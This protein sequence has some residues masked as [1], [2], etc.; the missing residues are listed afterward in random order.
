[1]D[2]DWYSEVGTFMIRLHLRSVLGVWLASWALGSLGLETLARGDEAVLPLHQRIDQLID[3]RRVGPPAPLANDAEFLRRIAIDLTGFPPSPEE[4]TAFLADQGADKRARAIDRLLA[5]PLHG[6]YLANA[7]DLWLMERRA[8][9]HVAAEEWQQYLLAAARENRPLNQVFKEILGADGTNPAVRP[10]ARFYLDREAEP[11]LITRDV[12]RIFLGRDMQCAQC[13]N[14][15]VIADYQ[16]SDYHGLLAFFSPAALQTRK[17][18]GKDQAVYAEKVGGTLAFDSVFV[19]DDHH[20]TG[21]R[22]L[23]E[24]ELVE[25]DFPPGT[26]Y[27]VK[28]AD[29]VVPVPKFSRRTQLASHLTAGSNQAFNANLANRLWALLMGRGLVH[30]L[31]LHHPSNPPSHPELLAL[32]ANELVA[33]NFDARSFLRE[34]A[35]TQT[36]QRA[37]DLPGEAETKAPSA[38]EIASM[39]AV[40]GGRTESLKAEAKAAHDAY[41]AAINA[42]HA[43]ESKLVP[44]MGELTQAE[45]KHAGADKTQADAQKALEAAKAQVVARTAVSKTVGEAAAKA[46]EAAKLLP[47][48]PNLAA[49]AKTFADRNQALTAEI[50]ALTKAAADKEPPLKAASDALAAVGTEVEVART[51]VKP[52]RDEVRGK[53]QDVLA[54]RRKAAETQTTLEVHQKRVEHLQSLAQRATLKNQVDAARQGLANL[55]QELAGAQK[56]VTEHEAAH[57]A[58]E[59]EIAQLDQ[60]QQSAEQARIQAEAA[61][62]N[63]QKGVANLDAAAKGVEAAREQFPGDPALPEL[64]KTLKAKVEGLQAAS[65]PLVAKRDEAVADLRAKVMAFAASKVALDASA[66]EKAKRDAAAK[67]VQERL[68]QAEGT[69][70]AQL[71]ELDV[72][73][74]QMVTEQS[75]AFQLA[76]LKPLS[77]EQLCWSLLKVTG[78]FDRTYQ[79][80]EAALNKEKPLADAAKND[81]AQLKARGLE[82][83]QRTFAKFKGEVAAFVQVYAASAGQPQTDFFATADQALFAT[84]GGLVNAWLAPAAGNVTDRVVREPSSEKGAV[85]LYLTLLGRQP[86]AQESAEVIQALNEAGPNKAAVAQELAWGLLTSVEFRFNH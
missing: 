43:S 76:Q 26:E 29:N 14:H 67:A 51:K 44:V 69:L 80:E 50:A 58:L 2:L 17:V 68:T 42:W 71:T 39:L 30:P 34:V 56:L 63:Q 74:A 83:E 13:H 54:T 64:S 28:P 10:A 52:I 70:K 16:Q 36:Y 65:A 32:L 73:T 40:E 78:V 62:A 53:E 55:G 79:A 8:G 75:D 20:L 46:D 48:E 4:V 84:N 66:A 37:I 11:N 77:P 41:R 60:A 3:A 61:L 49:A 57:R 33:R 23:G 24:T 21:P 6:R 35:L 18:D 81:P 19:K 9:K 12:G 59:A 45:A 31:D 27:E 72:A 7:L 1:M 25:P 47:A 85:D 5:S 22:V 15:P 86:N 38:E 82:V